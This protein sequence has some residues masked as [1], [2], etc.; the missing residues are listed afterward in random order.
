MSIPRP[1]IHRDEA[2]QFA[3]DQNPGARAYL[4]TQMWMDN[5]GTHPI[6]PGDFPQYFAVVE[7]PPVKSGGRHEYGLRTLTCDRHVLNDGRQV[8]V[9]GGCGRPGPVVLERMDKQ[10]ERLRRLQVMI[11]GMNLRMLYL[12]ERGEGDP[13]AWEWDGWGTLDWPG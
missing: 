4:L 6:F 3:I 13:M 1:V 2:L 7:D 9:R 10:R 11:L 8:H 12:D 5:T